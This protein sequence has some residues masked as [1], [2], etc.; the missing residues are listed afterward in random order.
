MNIVNIIHIGDEVKN[1]D[2]MSPEEQR[3]VAT[4]LNTQALTA[5]GYRPVEKEGTA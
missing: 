5:I 4:K 3:E 2:D 1:W